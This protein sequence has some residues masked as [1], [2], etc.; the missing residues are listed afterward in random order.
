MLIKLFSKE[1]REIFLNIIEN[2][3]NYINNRELFI[4]QYTKSVKGGKFIQSI[5]DSL[6]AF[7]YSKEDI[8]ILNN[9]SSINNNINSLLE[10]IQKLL[11]T[12]TNRIVLY[13][14]LLE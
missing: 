12:S 14:L 13:L 6:N 3:I 8:E 1:N 7:F 2:L 4:E 9:K 5:I 11:N 10:M